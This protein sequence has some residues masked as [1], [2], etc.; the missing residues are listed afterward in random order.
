MGLGSGAF[1]G[2]FSAPSRFEEGAGTNPEELIGAAHAGCYAMALAFGLAQAGHHPEHI[3]AQ[4]RVHLD[5][6]DGGFAI[7]L[8]ELAVQAKVPDITQE[9]FDEIAEATKTGCPVSVALASTKISLVAE[10]L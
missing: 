5:P 7:S 4:A 6:V 2:P 9:T 8:I 10:L 1:E 3:D